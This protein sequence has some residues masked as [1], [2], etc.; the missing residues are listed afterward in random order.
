M[1]LS[2]SKKKKK[3]MME[4]K[5]TLTSAIDSLA[6]NSFLAMPNFRLSLR[7]AKLAT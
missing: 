1:H 4:N 7:T 2:E 5:K 6:R 3:K